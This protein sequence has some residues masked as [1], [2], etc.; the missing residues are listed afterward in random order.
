VIE[1]ELGE[2]AAEW[3]ERT[4]IEQRLPPRVMDID[5]L[6]DVMRLM[7]LLT[8]EQPQALKDER[9]RAE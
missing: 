2:T 7:G 8:D 9:P 5:V 1:G 6:R 3:A 4:A